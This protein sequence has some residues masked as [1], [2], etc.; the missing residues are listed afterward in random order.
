MS[1][2]YN[3]QTYMLKSNEK[4]VNL[5]KQLEWFRNEALNLS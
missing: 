4:I 1:R 3:E 2:K 5:E